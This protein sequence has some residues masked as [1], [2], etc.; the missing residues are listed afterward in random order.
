MIY[1]NDSDLPRTR[2]ATGK[3]HKSIYKN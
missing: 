3:P 1:I 2:H